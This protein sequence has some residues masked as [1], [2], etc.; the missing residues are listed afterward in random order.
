MK[1]VTWKI[2]SFGKFSVIRNDINITA[3]NKRFSKKWKLFQYL[4]TYRQKKISHRKL[5]KVLDLEDSYLP[6]QALSALVYRLRKQIQ[7]EFFNKIDNDEQ[8]ICSKPGSYYFNKESNY[9]FDADIFEESINYCISLLSKNKNSEEIISSFTKAW[10]IYEQGDY[11]ETVKHSDEWLI[12]SRDYYR[13]SLINTLV[14]IRKKLA[15]NS[16]CHKLENYYQKLL[17]R[18]PY[19]NE[20]I[21]G[22]INLLLC[23]GDYYFALHK[24]EYFLAR[25]HERNLKVPEDLLE[26]Q[27]RLKG[28]NQVY[29]LGI[30]LD[31]IKDDRAD[32]ERDE[33]RK[34]YLSSPGTFIELFEIEFRRRFVVNYQSF[35]VN[36]SKNTP[37]KLDKNNAEIIRLLEEG[38]RPGDIF[39]IWDEDSILIL[40]VDI[41]SKEIEIL[42][43]RIIDLLK[44]KTDIDFNYNFS[45]LKKPKSKIYRVSD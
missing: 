34:A 23:I 14:H 26:L 12:S 10:E 16:S 43:D 27:K 33:E 7:G 4:L 38:L 32:N 35:I 6:E 13:N 24:L 15:N 1:V 9:I 42:Y 17:A 28:N 29:D 11:L 44:E 25:F 36:L 37:L 39:S 31:N 45:K 40:M 22:Y 8:L 5:I 19:N 41:N 30:Y 18:Y 3:K 21:I 20:L 2:N